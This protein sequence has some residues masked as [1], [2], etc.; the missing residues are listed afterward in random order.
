MLDVINVGNYLAALVWGEEQIN[1]L[2]IQR[3]P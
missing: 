1:I 2:E 3:L